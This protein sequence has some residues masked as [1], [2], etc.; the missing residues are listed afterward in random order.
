MTEVS[1]S[2]LTTSPIPGLY[3]LPDLLLSSETCT[4]LAQ[5]LESTFFASPGVNQVMLFGKADS[6]GSTSLPPYLELLLLEASEMLL[7]HLPPGIHQ[8]VFEPCKTLKDGTQGEPRAR[9]AILNH[10]SPGEGITPHVDLLGRFDDGILGISLGSGCA[11]DFERVEDDADKLQLS[12]QN[13][14]SLYLPVGSL[15]VLTGDARYKWTHG[16]AKR[17]EDTV[18]QEEEEGGSKVLRRGTR[19]SLTFRWLL[20]NAHVVGE[21]KTR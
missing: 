18:F 3:F 4:Q 16:I 5:Y 11:M 17:T 15:L 19:M 8:T 13:A 10:Y 1:S 14:W 2:R 12:G 9:Q 6:S 21:E 7:P 20:P